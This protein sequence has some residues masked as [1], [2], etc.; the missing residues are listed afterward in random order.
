RLTLLWPHRHHP[1]ADAV[2]EAASRHAPRES[3]ALAAFARLHSQLDA[4]SSIESADE[5][6]RALETVAAAVADTL[7]FDAVVV[8]L[9]R[10]AWDDFIVSTVHGDESL[11]A[12][13]LGATYSW[14]DWESMLAERFRHGGAYLVYDGELDWDQQSGKR[15]VPE[16]IVP[17]DGPNAWKVED[18]IFVPFHHSDGSLLGIFNVGS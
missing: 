5:L 10:K 12:A 2:S 17:S 8:N 14:E 6:P 18:E 13:L 16:D 1:M 7:G 3:G 4:A 11:R 15:I 9:Y